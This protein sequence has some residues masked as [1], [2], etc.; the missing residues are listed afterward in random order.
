MDSES[1]STLEPQPTALEPTTVLPPVPAR[2]QLIAP[3]WHT[4]ALIALIVGYSY[5]GSSRGVSAPT[6]A[7]PQKFLVVQ[8]ILTMIF[9]GF[10]LFLVWLGIRM[11]GVRLR[12]LIGGR[13]SSPEDFLIDAGIAI[14]FWIIALLILAGLGYLLGLA[15]PAQQKAVKELANLIAPQNWST[16]V[17]WIL[18]SSIAGFVEEIVFRGYLQRQLGI[19]TRSMLIGVI[20]S[21]VVFGSGHGYEGSR[22]MALIVVYGIMFGLLALWRKS[23]RPGMI[24]HAW[25]DAFEGILLRFM[26]QMS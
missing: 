9:E 10:L 15:S 14:A 5:L 19:L 24:A 8:Y 3:L 26:S 11:K 18:L 6:Q 4:A 21:A 22:R 12:E 20:L 1:P 17:L 7:I 25:H 16:I 23:L 13:W 2:P